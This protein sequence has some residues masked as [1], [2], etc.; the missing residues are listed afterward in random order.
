[1]EPISLQ[2]ITKIIGEASDEELIPALIML[3]LKSMD[4]EAP[5]LGER[6]KL[7]ALT[8][9]LVVRYTK[10]VRP[11]EYVA[12]LSDAASDDQIA[13]EYRPGTYL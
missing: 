1:M 12:T 6:I 13:N 7:A 2:D 9:E 10:L 8:S 11:N 3:S 4:D 5:N